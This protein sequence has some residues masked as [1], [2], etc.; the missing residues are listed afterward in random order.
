MQEDEDVIQK[1]LDTIQVW[2]DHHYPIKARGLTKVYNNGVEAVSHNSFNVKNGEVFGLLGPNGAGKSSMFNMVTLDL[3][4]NDGDIK[5]QSRE[6]DNLEIIRDGIKYG[7][8]PQYNTIWE[9]LTV[10]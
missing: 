6:I 5:I 3:K 4:R 10:D 7:T 9:T 2:D 8:R 1:K